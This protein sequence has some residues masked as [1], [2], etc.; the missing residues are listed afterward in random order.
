M[1]QFATMKSLITHSVRNVKRLG[2][3]CIKNTRFAAGVCGISHFLRSCGLVFV[4][5]AVVLV[6]EHIVV[7]VLVFIVVFILFIVEHIVIRI[8]SL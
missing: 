6:V 1:T 8:T 4:V 5:E 3:C 2:E 7:V